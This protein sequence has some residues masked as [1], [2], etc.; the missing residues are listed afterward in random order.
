MLSTAPQTPRIGRLP[1]SMKDV[2]TFFSTVTRFKCAISAVRM[3][4]A[5]IDAVCSTIF[6]QIRNAHRIV[7]DMVPIG[8]LPCF[9]IRDIQPIFGFHA[10]TATPDAWKLDAHR[11]A[12]AYGAAQYLD[13]SAM[14][15]VL[16]VIVGHIVDVIHASYSS[17]SAENNR[18]IR[19]KH[20]QTAQPLLTTVLL[21]GSHVLPERKHCLS[22]QI[23]AETRPRSASG[24]FVS[25][26][27]SVSDLELWLSV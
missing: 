18:I 9:Q 14:H 23:H 25:S 2:R 19:V 22:R 4:A 1:I 26:A 10:P 12:K 11:I 16:N 21:D 3:F 15:Y 20:I 5:Y 6:A 24:R 17:A 27:V 8:S 7:A 13:S